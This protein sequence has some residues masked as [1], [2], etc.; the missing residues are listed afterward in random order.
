MDDRLTERQE[1]IL[2]S[3]VDKRLHSSMDRLARD[4]AREDP[5]ISRKMIRA[6]VSRQADIIEGDTG[7]LDIPPDKRAAVHRAFLDLDAKLLPLFIE[8][9]R[10]LHPDGL[11]RKAERSLGVA[12]E[13]AAAALALAVKDVELNKSEILAR[14]DIAQG[15][16]GRVRHVWE[17]EAR[18]TLTPT[19]DLREKAD[20]YNLAIAG[21]ERSLPELKG[22]ARPAA[23]PV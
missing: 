18:L 6:W 9:A 1:W 5:S 19:P 16:M 23:F 8:E 4:A 13:Y 7:R 17:K 14:V 11:H 15:W 10:R 20:L 2:L 21:L 3:I 22:L 12:L